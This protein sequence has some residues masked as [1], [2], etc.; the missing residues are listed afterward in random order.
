MKKVFTLRLLIQIKLY[1]KFTKEEAFE[2]IKSNLTKNKKTL[3]M[4]ERSINEQLETLMNIVAND[5]MELDDFISKVQPMFNTMDANV[6][7]DRSEFVKEW[8]LKHPEK[9]GEEKIEDEKKPEET[10][11]DPTL[12][13]L[14]EE[15]KALKQG[16]EEA[17]AEKSIATKRNDLLKVMREKGIKNEQWA[18]DYLAEIAIT[19]DLD[20]ESR[21]ES[22]LK[23]YN[24]SSAVDDI[25]HTPMATSSSEKGNK[26]LL[27][28]VKEIMKNR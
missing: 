10:V 20:V 4:S 5:E 1:M 6:G 25:V 26:G 23:L 11:T 18:N 19:E 16:F 24:R 28:D 3:Q 12:K 15:V 7:N 14:L 17:R 8:K 22:A 9:K 21:A 27:D 2:K 13:S